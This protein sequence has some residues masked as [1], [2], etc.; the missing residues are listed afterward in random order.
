MS[1]KLIEKVLINYK[2][3]EEII[4]LEEEVTLETI[5]YTN[6]PMSN[7]GCSKPTENEAI[8]L[9]DRKEKINYIANL[10]NIIRIATNRL[11][12]LEKK[13]IELFYFEQ[14]NW[15]EVAVIVRFSKRHCQRTRRIAIKKL[16][17]LCFIANTDSYNMLI[18]ELLY[19]RIS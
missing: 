17:L 6:G 12:V 18:D 14:K 11:P 15:D 7:M 19:D 10:I 8:R 9:L 5:E 1:Y 4:N 16:S 3:L 2:F 13:V